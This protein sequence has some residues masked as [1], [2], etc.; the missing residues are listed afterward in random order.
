[1]NYLT[2]LSLEHQVLLLTWW[3]FVWKIILWFFIAYIGAIF[4][5]F[6]GVI[7]MRKHQNGGKFNLELITGRSRCDHCKTQL[8]WY[9]NIPFFSFIFLRGK[10][11]FCKN[12]ISPILLFVEISFFIDMLCV[13][14]VFFRKSL[15]IEK[16]EPVHYEWWWYVLFVLTLSL[17]FFIEMK[18]YERMMVQFHWKP[19][20]TIEKKQP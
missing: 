10:C 13:V 3:L 4:G 17:L 15:Q 16:I 12:R 14:W 11:W 19:K 8:K 18:V 1:M 9:H 20:M 7:V 6:L 2:S 5:S